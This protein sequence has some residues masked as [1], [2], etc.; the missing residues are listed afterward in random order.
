ML[1]HTANTR[2]DRERSIKE[3]LRTRAEWKRSQS[4]RRS[5]SVFE[6]VANTSKTI[7]S[8]DFQPSSCKVPL[9]RGL[10]IRKENMT[11]SWDGMLMKGKK[12]VEMKF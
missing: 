5:G 1:A 3:R 12:G 10:S 6:D 11:K 8:K 7:P 4:R 9:T 2:R